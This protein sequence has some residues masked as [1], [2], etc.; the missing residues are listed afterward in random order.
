MILPEF[1]LQKDDY[2]KFHSYLDITTFVRVLS[3]EL[4]DHQVASSAAFPDSRMQ[5]YLHDTPETLQNEVT[6]AFITLAE[7]PHSGPTLVGLLLQ[8]AQ[9]EQYQV[10]GTIEIQIAAGGYHSEWLL[11]IDFFDTWTRETLRLI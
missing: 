11:P 9:D 4:D 2:T 10:V 8:E 6:V 7:M 1:V 3:I 5:V